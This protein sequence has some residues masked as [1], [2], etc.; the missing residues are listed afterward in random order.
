MLQ[1]AIEYQ[2]SLTPAKI[3]INVQVVWYLRER[4]SEIIADCD[5]QRQSSPLMGAQVQ[6]I[7]VSLTTTTET[8][9]TKI[10]IL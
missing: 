10:E 9:K 1:H 8:I 2:F 4:N 6:Y 7:T 5:R 3:N